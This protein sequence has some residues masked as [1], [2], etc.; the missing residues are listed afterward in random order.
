MKKYD[1]RSR[2]LART[3]FWD[4]HDRETYECPDCERREEEIEGSFEI[5]HKNS[6][7]MDNRFE[8]TVGLC[9]LCHKLREDKKPTF[10][11]IRNLREAVIDAGEEPPPE[12]EEEVDDTG[13]V[14]DSRKALR[15][16]QE[17]WDPGDGDGVDISSDSDLPETL[18]RIKERRWGDA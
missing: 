13:E 1:D 14:M 8:N 11:Q 3:I 18:E 6:E 9:G 12:E 17:R 15:R 2:R 7:P 16:L 4:R 10:P 5:H